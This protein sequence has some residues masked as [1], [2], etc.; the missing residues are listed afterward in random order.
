MV[1]FDNEITNESTQL[2]PFYSTQQRT[3]DQT[4]FPQKVVIPPIEHN[5]CIV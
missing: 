2:F 4:H 1:S 3:K 5:K